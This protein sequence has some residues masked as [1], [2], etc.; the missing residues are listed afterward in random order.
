MALRDSGRYL[1][2]ACEEGKLVMIDTESGIPQM[3]TTFG[4]NLNQVSY[5]SRTGYIY[6]PSGSSEIM[7]VFKISPPDP[8]ATPTN[9]PFWNVLLP[10]QGTPTP[11]P[12]FRV[13]PGEAAT[14]EEAQILKQIYTADTGRDANCVTGDKY[15]NVWICD[16]YKGLILFLEGSNGEGY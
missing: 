10:E 2:V 4:D 11:V 16:P 12:S 7:G 3:S 14:T 5:I 15:G 1:F 13:Y 8:T 9:E 6:L